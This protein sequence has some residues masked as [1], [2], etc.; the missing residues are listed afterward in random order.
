MTDKS[1]P[2]NGYQIDLDDTISDWSNAVKDAMKAVDGEVEGPTTVDPRVDDGNVVV[3]G[4]DED[5]AAMEDELAT[6]DEGDDG[7]ADSDG[8]GAVGEDTSTELPA[9]VVDRLVRLENEGDALRDRLARTLA[10]FE[11]SRKRAER[12]KET[13][14]RFAN[15]DCLKDFLDVFDNLERALAA[16][17]TVDDVKKGV[18]L[19]AR[20]FEGVLKRYGVQ[21][22]GAVG[23]AF[24][25]QIHEA[26]ASQPDDDVEVPTVVSEMQRGYLLHDRLLRPA[27]VSVAMPAPKPA[28]SEPEAAASEEEADAPMPEPSAD[29]TIFRG[30]AVDLD[31]RTDLDENSESSPADEDT[32]DGDSSSVK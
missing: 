16:T 13:L 15:F 19:T 11:N 7:A 21:A 32:E 18:D 30:S 24:D 4:E 29:E 10:D 12:E 6:D 28:A 26:V 31:E 27:M 20:Q 17:G 22:V 25:P 2:G 8:R 3:V 1:G 23:E 9:E 5:L 14:L